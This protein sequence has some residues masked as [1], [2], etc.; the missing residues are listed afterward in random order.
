MYYQSTSPYKSVHPNDEC[1][2][3]R[4]LLPQK[5]VLFYIFKRNRQ[6]IKP[7]AGD[8]LD[9]CPRNLNSNYTPNFS[10]RLLGKSL[11]V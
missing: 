2:Y 6:K 11:G 5:H 8:H 4:V 9:G 1:R 7:K 3:L 10:S